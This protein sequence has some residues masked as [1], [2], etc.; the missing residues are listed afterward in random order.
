MGVGVDGGVGC[1]YV[2]VGGMGWVVGWWRWALVGARMAAVGGA[3]WSLR[4]CCAVG[5]D[6]D[7]W[8]GNPYTQPPTQPIN[9]TTLEPHALEPP[10]PPPHLIDNSAPQE[11]AQQ[12]HRVRYVQHQVVGG[13]EEAREARRYL[14]VWC[15]GCGVRGCVCVWMWGLVVR[16][17]HWMCGGAW[18]W[19]L[20]CGCGGCWCCWCCWCVDVGVVGVRLWEGACVVQARFGVAGV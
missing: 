12:V 14:C 20:V 3:W 13:G 7:P 15:I 1:V 18:M 5:M 17:V 19:G 4:A 9:L 10:P 8:G 2:C 11:E 6:Q 16:V